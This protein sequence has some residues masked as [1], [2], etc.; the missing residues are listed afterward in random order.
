MAAGM[1]NAS[2]LLK[3]GKASMDDRLFTLVL[4]YFSAEL[5][6]LGHAGK[7]VLTLDNHDSHERSAPIARA[8]ADGAI[9][10]ALPSHCT[11]LAQTL[12]LGFFKSL[13]ARWKAAVSDWL[14]SVNSESACTSKDVFF[15]LM[16][17]A[18]SNACKPET[19]IKAWKKMGLEFRPRPAQMSGGRNTDRAG[20]AHANITVINRLA[21]ADSQLGGS[22]LRDARGTATQQ[23]VRI[24]SGEKSGEPQHE[25]LTFDFSEEGKKKMTPAELAMFQATKTCVL[26]QPGRAFHLTHRP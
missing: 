1:P 21:I 24:N 2:L 9:T 14:D 19:A 18:R 23:T 13:K 5:K 4:E 3:R 20:N 7:H 8:I 12:D 16:K 15:T 10:I 6:R 26:S 17:T 22:E 25:T 11:H